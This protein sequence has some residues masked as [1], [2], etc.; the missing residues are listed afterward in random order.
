MYIGFVEKGFQTSTEV[1]EASL[2]NPKDAK[3]KA[4]LFG[5]YAFFENLHYA[6]IYM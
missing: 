6:H 2:A 5:C 3:A 1:G 4:A